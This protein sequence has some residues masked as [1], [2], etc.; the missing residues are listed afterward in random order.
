MHRVSALA[1]RRV[2]TARGRCALSAALP[3]PDRRYRHQK[4]VR[5][6]AR[7]PWP[8]RTRAPRIYIYIP[9]RHAR[10]RKKRNP[11]RR[12]A[13][14]RWDSVGRGRFF[15]G[16][17][18]IHTRVS[19]TAASTRA[20]LRCP[21]NEWRPPPSVWRKTAFLRSTSRALSYLSSRRAGVRGGGQNGGIC[22]GPSVFK[23]LAL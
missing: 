1:A 12:R 14:P 9:T 17:R 19:R 10:M 16:R 7:T 6:H 21:A 5:T 8:S 13:G 22:P 15:P 23:G 20:R 3:L 11:D 2:S 18:F 4:S